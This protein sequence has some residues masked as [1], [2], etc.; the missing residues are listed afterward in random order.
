MP[1]QILDGK[2][3]RGQIK[4]GVAWDVA[5]LKKKGAV[6][7]LV[8]VRAGDDP[9][10][11]YYIKSQREAAEEV[12][13]AYEAVELPGTIG[14]A[15]LLARIANLNADDSVTGI[16]VQ[17]PLPEGVSTD[18]VQASIAPEKDVEGV[19]PVNQGL[20]FLGRPN[21]VPATAAA[22]IEVARAS[23]VEFKGKEAVIVGRSVVVGK[24]AALLLLA[25]HA[26]VQWCHTRT[27]DLG[28]HTRN[29]DILIACAGKA[30]LITGDMI[31]PGAVV[32]DVGIN[33]IKVKNKKTG[34]KKRKTVGDVKFKEAVE[35]AGWISPVPGG[36]GPVTVAM[37]MANTVEAAKAKLD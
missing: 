32:V 19:T 5:A 2:E 20:L 15:E 29:A 27:V 3:I 26:T 11:G 24:P 37:L 9:A 13:I 4:G 18:S 30:R 12:G 31:K 7:K 36:V 1:A 14:E 10:T 33:V 28:A 8:A 34:E 16:I 25:E 35:V 22:A 17:V 23:E 6:P 21:L